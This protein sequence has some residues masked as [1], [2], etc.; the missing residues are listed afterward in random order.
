MLI[1]NR[2]PPR[3]EKL[4]ENPSRK[5]KKWFRRGELEKRRGLMDQLHVGIALDCLR[6]RYGRLEDKVEIYYIDLLLERGSPKDLLTAISFDTIDPFRKVLLADSFTK[7]LSSPSGRANTPI[8][9]RMRLLAQA[10]ELL[11]Q[12]KVNNFNAQLALVRV[13]Y[14]THDMVAPH[15]FV[16]GLMQRVLQSDRVEDTPKRFLQ[17]YTKDCAKCHPK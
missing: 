8:I 2:Q 4:P 9:E 7:Q 10:V 5:Q 12:G 17:V 6:S 1:K 16:A 15:S 11:E 3:I 13:L 14:E